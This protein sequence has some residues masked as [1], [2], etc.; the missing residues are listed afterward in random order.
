MVIM[1]QISTNIKTFSINAKNDIIKKYLIQHGVASINLELIPE[2]KQR[3][4]DFQI[5]IDG[6]DGNFLYWGSVNN[7]NL[8]T[9]FESYLSRLGKN[10]KVDITSISNLTIRIAKDVAKHFNTEFAW[11]ETKTFLANDTFI[12]PRWHTDNKFF[13]PY[14]VYKFVWA[15]KG[16]QTRF[17]MNKDQEKFKELTVQEVNA[18]H[19]TGNNIRVRKEIDQIVD[20]IEISGKEKAA[21]Y[22]SGGENPVVH[23][24]PHMDED[25]LFIAIVPGTK[26][27][28]NEW[29]E[30]KKQKDVLKKI[31]NRKWHYYAL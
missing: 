10:K 14:T 3:L 29:Y 9:N 13:I 23:S 20:E 26:K 22:R 1:T 18:G 19:G 4:R 2:E 21:L 6:S 16:P 25:R 30:R 8:L 5:Q 15:A 28:I 27:E 17:G 31:Q 11:I 7:A 12:V 24:E